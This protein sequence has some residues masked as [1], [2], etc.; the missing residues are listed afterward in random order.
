[1]KTAIPRA[2]IHETEARC[3]SAMRLDPLDVQKCVTEGLSPAHFTKSIHASIFTAMRQLSATGDAF[4][5]ESIWR[6]V[7]PEVSLFELAQLLGTEPTSMHRRRLTA[8]ILTESKRRAVTASLARAQEALSADDPTADWS[9]V[10]ETVEPLLQKAHELAA[11]NQTQDRASV[12]AEAKEL[13]G[14]PDN[15][16]MPGPFPVWDRASRKLRAGELCVLA[17]R[18]GDGKS[19]LALQFATACVKAGQTALL[20]SLEMSEAEVLAR[21]AV[22]SARSDKQGDTVPELDRIARQAYS[23]HDVRSAHTVAQIESRA[24][25]TAAT[26]RLGLIIIDYL[27]LIAPPADLKGANREQQVSALSRRFKLLAGELRC[28]VLLLSQLNRS[29]EKEDREPRLSDLRES[30]AIEQDADAVWLLHRDNPTDA[31]NT[32]AVKLI[33]AKRRNWQPNIFIR[34]GFT[35][36]IVS[37]APFG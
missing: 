30:G 24:R 21:L 35:G 10:W 13:L 19:A 29:S 12:I 4:D 9:E 32:V 31:G 16:G 26:G 27:Q 22:Q 14:P 20:F 37:F 28:P 2:H 34:L 25:L 7:G 23:I 8:E 11:G 5:E 33:Q 15:S 36:R 18:P 17:G 3:L 6:L 1:M